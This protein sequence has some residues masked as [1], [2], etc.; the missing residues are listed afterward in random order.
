M[1]QYTCTEKSYSATAS[2]VLTDTM[3]A[4]EDRLLLCELESVTSNLEPPE[5]LENIF[6]PALVKT[7][8]IEEV[9]CMRQSYKAKNSLRFFWR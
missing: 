4:G 9:S 6:R 5:D 1:K 7:K 8:Y 2:G 3:C